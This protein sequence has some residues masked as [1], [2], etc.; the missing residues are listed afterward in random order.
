MGKGKGLGLGLELGLGSG[1]RYGLGFGLCHTCRTSSEAS[2]R[3][4]CAVWPSCHRNSRVR[5]KG[6]GCLNSHRTTLFHWVGVGVGVGV[7]LGLG[8]GLGPGPG[9]RAGVRVRAHLVEL[10]REV[11]M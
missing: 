10:E 5:R 7:A 3:E 8:L 4:P 1:L 2:S 6:V 9:S 11:A